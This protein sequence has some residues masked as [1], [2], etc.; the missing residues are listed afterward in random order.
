ME[1]PANCAGSSR[2]AA[3]VSYQSWWGR[4]F[5]DAAVFEPPM[6]LYPT[7]TSSLVQME[8]GRLISLVGC[9]YSVWDEYVCLFT[10]PQEKLQNTP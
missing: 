9:Q 1:L 4:L 7:P 5:N 6:L 10:S 8:L 2:A 3:S